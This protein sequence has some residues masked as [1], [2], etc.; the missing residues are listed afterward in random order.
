MAPKKKK[1]KLNTDEQSITNFMF[2]HSTIGGKKSSKAV[3]K[4]DTT[5]IGEDKSKDIMNKLFEDLD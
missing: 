5:K 1:R 4:A 2:P 3:S